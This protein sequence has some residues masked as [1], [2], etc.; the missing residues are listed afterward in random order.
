MHGGICPQP[1]NG[2]V[3]RRYYSPSAIRTYIIYV[4]SLLVSQPA[5]TIVPTV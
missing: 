2:A 1:I 3:H 5:C 4:S